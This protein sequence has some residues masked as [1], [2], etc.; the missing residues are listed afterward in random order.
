MG[1]ELGLSI[2]GFRIQWFHLVDFLTSVG[3]WWPA[4]PALGVS[5]KANQSLQI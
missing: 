4:D 2:K 5:T 1:L 3:E